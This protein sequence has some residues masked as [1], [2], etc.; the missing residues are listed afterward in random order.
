MSETVKKEFFAPSVSDRKVEG[1]VTTRSAEP[2]IAEDIKPEKEI[3]L[4]DSPKAEDSSLRLRICPACGLRMDDK[5]NIDIS[6]DDKLRWLRYVCG[7]PRYTKTFDL[8]G[9]RLKLI[10]R[11]LT[12]EETDSIFNQLND[13]V[14]S[15]KLTGVPAYASPAYIARMYRLLLTTSLA[16][17]EKLMPDKLD[18]PLVEI[19]PEVNAENYPSGAKDGHRPVAI[20]HDKI[21]GKMGEG[22]VAALLAAYR[23]LEVLITTLVRHSEQPDFWLPAD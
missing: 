4:E 23:H 13:E 6:E 7:E 5:D 15:G 21:L 16:R 22:M 20:A 2:V 3:K 8:Y 19:Y 14:T 11:S 18:Q 17:I 12:T 1:I 10:L 9:G